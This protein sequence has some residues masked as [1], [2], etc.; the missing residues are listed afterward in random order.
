VRFVQYAQRAAGTVFVLTAGALVVFEAVKDTKP[1]GDAVLPVLWGA[2][3]A[4]AVIWLVAEGVQLRAERAK[5]T[6]GSDAMNRLIRRQFRNMKRRR[7]WRRALRRPVSP[8][9]I[10]LPIA[11][12]STPDHSPSPLEAWLEERLRDQ[13][14]IERERGVRG[15]REY[16]A[17]MQAWDAQNVYELAGIDPDTLVVNRSVAIAPGLTDS[18]RG[19]PPGH[20]PG[21]EHE[22]AYC[23]RQVAWLK[24]TLRRLH[25]GDAPTAPES[26]PKDSVSPEHRDMLKSISGYLLSYLQASQTAFYGAKGDELKAQSFG[27]HFPEV[28]ER[29]AAWN[30]RIAALESQ[31]G[32]LRAWVEERIKALA[33]DRP[34]F[35]WGYAGLI[36]EHAVVE[37]AELPF[38]VLQL[39]PLWL[40]LGAYAVA[41]EPPPNGR[42]REGIEDELRG[43]LAEARRQPQCAQIRQIRDSLSETSEPLINELELIHAKDV[44]NGLGDC[45]LCR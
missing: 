31:Q 14:A 9:E 36:A 5:A 16:L 4:S 30:E 13:A 19:S 44:I 32:E 15:E 33:Y 7:F 41:P 39:Q 37:G 2:C 24:D 29:V 6:S 42:T 8:R 12:P 26:M 21:V 38:H 23:E 20:P 3:G 34:P 45:V 10:R 28:A 27:E 43:V 1:S 35:A 40:H 18:Y 25:G 11:T 17:R 22:R